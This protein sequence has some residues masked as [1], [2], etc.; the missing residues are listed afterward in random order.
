MLLQIVNFGSTSRNGRKDVIVSRQGLRCRQIIVVVFFQSGNVT[1]NK[2]VR[3]KGH[4]AA[5]PSSTGETGSK[6]SIFFAECDKLVKLWMGALVEYGAAVVALE[7]Q[8]A[9]STQA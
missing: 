6:C 8:L 2:M 3:Y 5:T 7:H 9:Q 4:N 1:V